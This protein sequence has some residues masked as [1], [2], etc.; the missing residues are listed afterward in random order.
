MKFR[1]SLI[2]AAVVASLTMGGLPAQ[3]AKPINVLVIDSGSDFTHKVLHPMANPNNAELNGKAGVDDDKNG[4]TDDVYGWNFV[5]NNST[6]VNLEDTPPEYDKV[7]KVMRDI[8]KMQQFGKEAFTDEEWNWF[9]KNYNDPK[10]SPWI[11]FCGGWAHGTHCAGIIANNNKD[12]SLNAVRHIPTGSAP[13][14]WIK[15]AFIKLRFKLAEHS[16]GKK[17][18]YE[19]LDA[20]FTQ[21][22]KDYAKEIEPQA[23]YIA[24]FKPRLINCSFGS[25]NTMLLL[26]MHYNLSKWGFKKLKNE[27]VQKIANLFV[28]KAFLPRDKALFAHC[29]DALIFI[30]AGNSSENLDGLVTSPNNVPIENKI[31]VAATNDNHSLADFSCYGEKIVDVA[32]PGVNIYATY[33]NQKMGH[34]S[35]TSMACPNAV[36]MASLVLKANPDL[37]PLELKK[38]LLDTVDVKEWL[39]GKVRSSGVINVDRAV[40]AA[41]KMKEGKNITTAIS[42]A[43]KNVADMAVKRA[44][45][46]GPNLKDPVV[47]KIYYSNVF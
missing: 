41:K 38:I 40:Y 19:D 30:A 37:T 43:R 2:L 42:E 24:Q 8:N 31:V 28:T 34:M 16:I 35:G 10:L 46:S 47:K 12:V 45:H 25:E 15:D 44:R 22:G 33:P 27:E 29:K 6:L 3:A 18:T 11:E 14:S 32:V 23:K 4:Y 5:D 9:D 21:L 17:L 1:K 13:K 20:Y 7:L 36:G 26:T 39:K